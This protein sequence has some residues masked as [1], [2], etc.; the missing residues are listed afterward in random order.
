MGTYRALQYPGL[1]LAILLL[2]SCA[3]MNEP[4]PYELSQPLSRLTMTIQTIVLFPEG[5]EP[6]SD[7]RLIEAAWRERPELMGYF[8]GLPIRVR[9]SGTDVV[10]LLCS[11]DGR[12]AWMEDASWTPGVDLEWHEIDPKRPAEFSLDPG[13]R[14]D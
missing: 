6:L 8:Q 1:V 13:V 9:R 3:S 12:Y 11:P 7:D 4:K 5:G 2:L 14:H 10:V